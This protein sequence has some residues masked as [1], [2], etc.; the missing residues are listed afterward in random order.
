MHRTGQL[1]LRAFWVSCSH[2]TMLTER[3]FRHPAVEKFESQKRQ[4]ISPQYG[5]KKFDRRTVNTMRDQ[6]A[7]P[8][9]FLY[10]KGVA[11]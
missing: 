9:K 4:I 11:A 7:R 1:K 6:D 2:G 10:G 8:S 3:K 5:K